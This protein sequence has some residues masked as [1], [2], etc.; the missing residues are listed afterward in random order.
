MARMEVSGADALIDDL[1]ELSRLP[2]ELAGDVL[3]AM[4]DVVLPA[5][6]KEI[7]RQW[8]GPYSTGFSAECIK[9][10]AVKLELDG[11]SVSIYPQGTRTRGKQKI[12]NGEIAF[13]N[14]YGAPGRGIA[15]RPAISTATAKS[16]EQAV[17]AGEKVY[18][19]Y[20]DSKNL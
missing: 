13:L 1:T 17:E 2:Y 6:Q 8:N 3:N 19:A 5:Q 10:T 4:A 12:R 18:N 14:E 7:K 9:K 16:E 15:A 11:H 20:L